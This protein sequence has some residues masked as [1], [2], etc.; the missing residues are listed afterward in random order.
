MFQNIILIVLLASLGY[1]GGKNILSQQKI[2]PFLGL[3]AG[4][5]TG[6]FILALEKR[7]EK[8]S[9]PAIVGG[10]FG[11]ILGL[12]ISVIFSHSLFASANLPSETISYL[13]LLV[14]SILGYLGWAIGLKKAKEVNLQQSKIFSPSLGCGPSY[15]ILDTSVIIDGRIFDICE[16]GFIEGTIVIPQ[17]VL[18]ELMH[19]ADSPDSLKK[20]RGRRGLEI[21]KKLQKQTEVKV[22]ITDQDFPR[23]KEVDHKL[24]ALALKIGGKIVTNDINLNEIAEIQGVTVLNI[25]QLASALK[26]I[27]LPGET[28][29]VTIQK[30]GKECGQGVAY[31]DDGTMVVV[32]DGKRIIG[33]T[34]EVSVTSVLQTTSGRMI[35]A[36]EK[37]DFHPQSI[38]RLK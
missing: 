16:T 9:L 11:L 32:K 36:E 28:I 18:Q 21:L 8:I 7:L 29:T 6:I 13:N 3:I 2:H 22:L 5:V 27:V 34:V 20:T 4:I 25:N 12:L 30:E 33:K 23:I 37:E 24:V 17:F 14:G 26:P 19:I 1:I 15:K 35:F 10:V 38:H 31:L